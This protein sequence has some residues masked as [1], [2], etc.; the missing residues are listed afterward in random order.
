MSLGD[1]FIKIIDKQQEEDEDF[2]DEI[3]DFFKGT[4]K[5]IF[6]QTENFKKMDYDSIKK[7]RDDLLHKNIELMTENIELKNR[8]EMLEK[9]FI[10]Y[11]L[12]I[13]DLD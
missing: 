10:S 9:E 3:A 7:E 2:P 11:K 4:I 6:N 1:A 5:T 13:L 12:K 8:L